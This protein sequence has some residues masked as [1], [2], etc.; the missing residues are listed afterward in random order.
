MSNFQSWNDISNFIRSI[1]VPGSKGNTTVEKLRSAFLAITNNMAVGGVDP[2]VDASWKVDV[3]YPRDI[4][5]V[6]WRDLWLVSNITNNVGIE[7][8]SALGVVNSTW[9]VVGSSAG[10]GIRPWE[11]IVYGNILEI[12]FAEDSI[13]YLDR[14]VVGADPFLSANFTTERAEGKWKSFTNAGFQPST[15]T[16]GTPVDD[17]RFYFD[18]VTEALMHYRDAVPT[19]GSLK[20]I[21][22]GDLYNH[23]KFNQDLIPGSNNA[24]V[25]TAETNIDSFRKIIGRRG[26]FYAIKTTGINNRFYSSLDGQT[27]IPSAGTTGSHNFRD[28]DISDSDTTIM[29]S[30]DNAPNN[31]HRSTDKGGSWAT[32]GSGVGV[33]LSAI[34]YIGSS[35]WV[36]CASSGE[37]LYSTDDGATFTAATVAAANAFQAIGYGAGKVWIVSNDGTNRFQLSTDYG[38][39]YTAKNMVNNRLFKATTYFINHVVVLRDGIG[40]FGHITVSDDFGDT[41]SERLIPLDSNKEMEG[42]IQIGQWLYLYGAAGWWFRTKDLTT[43]EVNYYFTPFKIIGMDWTTVNGFPELMAVCNTGH[44]TLPAEVYST[45]VTEP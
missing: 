23:F 7:P 15:G 11:A 36:A 4:Q 5:P 1:I 29:V 12:V 34:K 16:Q 33:L 38:V 31:F 41:W 21:D 10:S 17:D 39:T 32:V 40:T 3:T 6:L 27:F 9:R 14:D 43:Y 30:S 42:M 22:S 13:Y 45:L 28:F 35:R 24:L 2:Q 44:P 26:N 8:V 19:E 37:A 18:P 25:Q 20:R